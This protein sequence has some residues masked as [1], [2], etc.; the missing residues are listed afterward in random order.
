MIGA[1]C[2]SIL[3]DPYPLYEA[4]RASMPVCWDKVRGVWLLSRYADVMCALQD[5]RLSSAPKENSSGVG[6][7]TEP[8][9]DVKALLRLQLEM[10]DPP[11]HARRRALVQKALIERGKADV[12]QA[13]QQTVDALLSSRLSTGCL[14]VIQDF[15]APLTSRVLL[16]LLGVPE[17]RAGGFMRCV[18]AVVACFEHSC[19]GQR[20]GVARYPTVDEV[21]LELDQIIAASTCTKGPSLI[22]T[23]CNVEIDGQHLTPREVLANVILLF[24]AGDGTTTN[25]I[26]SGILALIRHPSAAA[27]LARRPSLIETAVEEVLR[28][29]SPIQSVVRTASVDFQLHR[30][31]IRRG[32][33]VVLLLGSANRDEG[34]FACAADFDITRTPNRHLAF[35]RGAHLC[36][37]A[38]LAR[39]QAQSA[40]RAFCGH[41]RALRLAVER[42]EWH[43]VACFR[44]PKRLPIHFDAE[45]EGTHGVAESFR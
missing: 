43:Q 23:L 19:P 37:G 9:E 1:D 44:G 30:W 5:P 27:E 2:A 6:G 42:I 3:D 15:A 17:D 31:T 16:R 26:G 32:D 11:A 39:A 24:A 29:E 8:G 35:G 18:S 20:A 45:V 22:Q 10:T 41:A 38:W 36:L 25:L 40:I 33:S 21:I 14:D 7:A 12:Y 13:I 4:L 28:Y 34:A